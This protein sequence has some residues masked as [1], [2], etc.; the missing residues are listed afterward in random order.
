MTRYIIRRILQAI[1]LLIIISVM[2]FVLLRNSG[3]PI[4]VM[5]GRRATRSDDRERLTRLLGLD[6]PMHIQYITWLIGNDWRLVDI[7]GDGIPGG[8]RLS[9]L[10]WSVYQ[11]PLC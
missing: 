7:D 4:A 2:I 9:I 10:L 5:G 11:I 3:D 6:Q 8:F 1:P